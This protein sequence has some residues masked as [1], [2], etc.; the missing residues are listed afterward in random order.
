MDN[1]I[2]MDDLGGPP[3][4]LETPISLLNPTN[5][6]WSSHPTNPTNQTVRDFTCPLPV[7][8]LYFLWEPYGW[9]GV[10]GW[11]VPLF[12]V[13]GIFWWNMDFDISKN[14]YHV[15]ISQNF[16][17]DKVEY[18]EKKHETKHTSYTRKKHPG[19]VMK[20]I[21][22][23][24]HLDPSVERCSFVVFLQQSF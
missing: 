6:P 15:L 19:I 20:R 8:F 4:F 3:L 24:F 21:Y 16:H 14:F 13:P 22:W 1:P 9:R 17:Q 5:H 18:L 12:R 2:K 10:G 11:G 23:N 7:P